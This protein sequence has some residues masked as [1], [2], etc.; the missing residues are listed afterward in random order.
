MALATTPHLAQPAVSERRAEGLV[1]MTDMD[2][3]RFDIRALS[4]TEE[5][6]QLAYARNM[7]FATAAASLAIVGAGAFFLSLWL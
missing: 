7:L 3:A 1:Q 6:Q 2:M 5:R 4:H